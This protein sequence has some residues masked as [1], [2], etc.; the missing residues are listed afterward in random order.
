[1]CVRLIVVIAYFVGCWDCGLIYLIVC[2]G[3]LLIVLYCRGS[4]LVLFSGCGMLVV[5][6]WCCVLDGVC[7]LV[8]VAFRAYVV[9]T[10]V[11]LVCCWLD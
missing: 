11:L 2:V 10:V 3:C 7:F 5:A 9:Y 4:L 6:W 1:M 8:V